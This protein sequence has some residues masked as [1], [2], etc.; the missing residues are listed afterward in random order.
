MS[1][2]QPLHRAV[3]GVGRGATHRHPFP[4]LLVH[5]LHQV[6]FDRHAAV[7]LRR[8][9]VELTAV[10]RHGVH[11]E[12]PHGR[13]GPTQEDQLDKLL[14]LAVD[15]GGGQLVALGVLPCAVLYEEAGRVGLV[16]DGDVACGGHLH[17]HQ[18]PD[19]VRG[20]FA[21]DG[22]V[23]FDAAAHLGGLRGHVG[24]VDPG[25]H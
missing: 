22:H 13:A 19:R 17:A 1:L 14:V 21:G 2:L 9:P 6:L 8:P 23:E 18:G 7:V 15:V 16:G 4:R 20:G 12:R 24:P 5:L 25:L 10:L 11:L 3:G